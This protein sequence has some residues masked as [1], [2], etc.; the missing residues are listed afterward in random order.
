MSG[1]PV[2]KW[3]EIP[4][5]RARVRLVGILIR[6][7]EGLGY[8]VDSWILFRLLDQLTVGDSVAVRELAMKITEASSL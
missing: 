2:V 3:R 4:E 7:S 8:F 1:A 5:G 6:A